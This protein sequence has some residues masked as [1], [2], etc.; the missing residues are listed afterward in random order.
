MDDFRGTDLIHYPAKMDKTLSGQRK[1]Q[2]AVLSAFGKPAVNSFPDA[3]FKTHWQGKRSHD[4]KWAGNKV[5][6]LKE[7]ICAP[8]KVK[9]NSS[10]PKKKVK[11]CSY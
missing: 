2:S 11:K 9:N 7:D 6:G 8:K 4:Y 3:P 5:Q 10:E 1:A